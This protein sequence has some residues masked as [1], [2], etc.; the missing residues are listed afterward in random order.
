MQNVMITFIQATYIIVEYVH[1]SNISALTDPIKTE[2]G[3]D[4]LLQ[5]FSFI[6]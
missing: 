4:Y 2:L 1:I 5:L 6:Q 3:I